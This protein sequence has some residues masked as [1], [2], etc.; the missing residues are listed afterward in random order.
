MYR[1][2]REVAQRLDLAVDPLTPVAALSVAEQQLVEIAK[3]INLQAKLIALDEPTAAL[4]NREVGRLHKLVHA[5]KRQNIAF[6]YVTHRL[7]EVTTICARFTILRDGKF[8]GARH[9][10][11]CA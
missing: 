11:Q 10:H 3:A 4:S 6:I 8:S 9:T 5:L 2:A 7:N 1:R